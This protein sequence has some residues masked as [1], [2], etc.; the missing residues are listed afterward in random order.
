L[1]LFQ[2][3]SDLKETG[4]FETPFGE[5]FG[6]T[7]I[8]GLP[9]RD[10]DALAFGVFPTPDT[11]PRVAYASRDVDFGIVLVPFEMPDV[12]RPSGEGAGQ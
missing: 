11:Q 3:G 12:I 8:C 2:R 4:D 6:H 10:T 7:V 9:K 5:L 1:G